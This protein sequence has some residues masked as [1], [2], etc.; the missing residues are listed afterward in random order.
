MK[1]AAQLYSLV[2]LNSPRSRRRLSTPLRAW[3]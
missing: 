3:P 2:P 1:E